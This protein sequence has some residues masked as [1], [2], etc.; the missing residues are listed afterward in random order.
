MCVC[1]VS[2][3]V[4][5]GPVL[6]PCAVGGCSRHRMFLFIIIIIKFYPIFRSWSVYDGSCFRFVLQFSQNGCGG[7]ERL[8]AVLSI[9][10][11][12]PFKHLIHLSLKF[13]PGTDSDLS[14]IHI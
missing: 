1:V 13:V 5:Y 6:P 2:A 8:T 10:E 9:V 3:I 14:L 12:N 11:T 7:G 4:N